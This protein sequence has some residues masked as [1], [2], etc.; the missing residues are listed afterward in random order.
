MAE[1]ITT[2]R[3]QILKGA[4]GLTAAGAAGAAAVIASTDGEMARRI[5]EHEAAAA[6]FN[7]AIDV[8]DATKPGSEERAAAWI[9]QDEACLDAEDALMRLCETAPT[10]TSEAKAKAAYLMIQMDG[11]DSLADDFARALLASIA[12]TPVAV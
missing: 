5:A 9:A 1:H 11:G 4:A 6:A 8:T 2:T 3:R 10:I 7:A 12:A